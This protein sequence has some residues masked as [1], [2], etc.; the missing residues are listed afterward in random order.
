M[1]FPLTVVYLLRI[2]YLCLPRYLISG[3][4]FFCSLVKI[5][6]FGQM[7]LLRSNKALLLC[8]KLLKVC[9]VIVHPSYIPVARTSGT[10][11]SP[12]TAKAIKVT[13]ITTIAVSFLVIVQF[14]L[15]LQ[16]TQMRIHMFFFIVL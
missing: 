1:F 15:V 5:D 3:N 16:T 2:M 4:V 12:K 8:S 13:Y 10:Q 11:Y 14:L 7:S 6:S 9:S